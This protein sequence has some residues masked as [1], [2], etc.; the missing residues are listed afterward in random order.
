MK[1]VTFILLIIPLV[2]VYS[3]CKKASKQDEETPVSYTC[4]ACKTTPDALAANDASAK[5][6]YKGVFIG[7][8]GTIKFDVNNA[9]TTVTAL[10]VIDGVSVTLTSTVTYTAGTAYTAPFTGTLNGSAV[11]INFTVGATGQS[12]TVTASSVP[13]HP[14]MGFVLSKETSTALVEAFEGTYTTS[15]PEKGTFNIVLSRSLKLWGAA[16]RKENA[17]QITNANG[18]ISGNDLITGGQVIGTM[19]QDALSGKSK[20]ANGSDVTITGKRTL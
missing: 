17:T 10:M 11:S 9:G 15:L 3:S 19:T 6:I 16:A 1:K 2:V 12:P 18:T 14:G 7:S 4:T 8:T 5:G 20:D 13:G